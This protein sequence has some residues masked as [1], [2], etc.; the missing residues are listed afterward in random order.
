MNVHQDRRNIDESVMNLDRSV[1]NVNQDR[2]S[3]AE[4]INKVFAPGHPHRPVNPA[5]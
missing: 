5:F 3:F 4:T 2:R 1:M